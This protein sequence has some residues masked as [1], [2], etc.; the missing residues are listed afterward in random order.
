VSEPETVD[1]NSKRY[2]TE[3]VSSMLQVLSQLSREL[4]QAGG[5]P[6]T[7]GAMSELF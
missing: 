2:R 5:N 6:S 7:S 4:G 3:A 1:N